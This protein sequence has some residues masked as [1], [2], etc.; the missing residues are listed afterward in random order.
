M[1]LGRIDPRSVC[2]LMLDEADRDGTRVTNLAL[3]KLLYFAH[4]RYLI[5]VRTPLVS[6]YFE[7]WQYGPVH[8][9]AYRAFKAAGDRPI[10]FRAHGQDPLTGQRQQLAL[11][12]DTSVYRL[13]RAVMV[14]YGRLTPGRLVE[15]S[16]AKGAPWDYVV[17]QARDNMAFGLR[18]SDDVIMERFKHHK[19]S[20]G[21]TPLP[22][23]PVE[24]SP[25]T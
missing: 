1:T 19:V 20:V 2:N 22:G 18:L 13:I 16:H 5:E 25:F 14:S 15:I 6:G 24:D 12:D 7:A 23:E 17:G 21:A 9:T 4:A 11:P 10:D 8:P 3:Q